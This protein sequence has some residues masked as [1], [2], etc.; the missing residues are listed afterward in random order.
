MYFSSQ[1]ENDNEYE[2]EPEIADEFDSDFDEDVSF[3][4]I[5]FSLT[6]ILSF[7]MFAAWLKFSVILY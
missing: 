4:V 5:I 3:Y 7:W 2:A 1:E 6:S